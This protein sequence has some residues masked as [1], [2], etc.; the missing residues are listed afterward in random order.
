MTRPGWIN[1]FM[2]MLPLIARRS[3]CERHQVGAIITIDNQIVTTG[4]NGAP[5]G[6]KHCSELGGCM[7]DRDKIPSGTRQEHC[8]AVHSEQNAILSAAARGISVAGGTMYVSLQPCGLCARSIINA[9][10][11]RVFYGEAYP[12]PPGIEMLQEAGIDVSHVPEIALE[13]P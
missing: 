11:S 1:Y 3:T 2:S 8:R 6:L 13:W 5:R 7:R 4:Y 12:D 9:Q 10:L